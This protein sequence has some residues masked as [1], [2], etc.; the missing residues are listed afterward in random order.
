MQFN[1]AVGIMHI[2]IVMFSAQYWAR[3]RT[4]VVVAQY[5]V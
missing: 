1:F 2:N 3:A 4:L 5:Y